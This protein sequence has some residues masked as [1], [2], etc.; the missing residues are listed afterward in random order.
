MKRL[1]LDLAQPTVFLSLLTLLAAANLW[2]KRKE[3]RGRLL[4][5]TVPLVLLVL[6]CMPATSYLALGLLEWS[7]P[8]LQRR[9]AD[10]EAIVVLSG[11][12]RVATSGGTQVELGEDTLCRCVRAAEVYRDGKR[13]PVVVSGGKFDAAAPGP[14]LAVAMG[15]FLR[16]QGVAEDDLIVEDRSLTTY[17]NAVESCRLLDERGIH[18]IVLVTDAAHLDRAVA[19]FRKQGAEVIPCGC[20]YRA[21]GIDWS[22]RAFL[23][24]PTAARGTQDALHEWLGSAWYRVQG[25]T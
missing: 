2:R 7:N 6:W 13:C 19:C 24:D 11:Y 20:R 5:L 15:D 1:L 18:K 10:T 22:L 3:N 4:W 21:L 23:P 8:P 14:A 9:P 16:R 17:Q 25:K 12:L